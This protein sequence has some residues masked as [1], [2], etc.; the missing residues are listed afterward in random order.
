M[1]NVGFLV[2]SIRKDSWN[3]KLSNWLIQNAT[4]FKGHIIEIGHLP[5]YNQDEDANPPKASVEFKKQIQEC[6]AII[7]VT[8][9]YNRSIPGVLKNAIDIA[10]RPYGQSAW[11]KKPAA[12]LSSSIGAIGGF[13][14]N[15]HLRQCLTFLN[16]PCL[17][18][19]EIYLGTIQNIF[20]DQGHITNE[21]TAQFLKQ[22]LA[23][24]NDW[25]T[26]TKK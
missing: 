3:R 5:H 21:N 11:D 15:H 4:Q 10:S 1:F 25:V 7:F 17:Q 23:T 6:D 18:Q 9:E 14:A 19:P 22:F 16:M 2:G 24:F 12:V 26:T 13:G 20:D 8:P